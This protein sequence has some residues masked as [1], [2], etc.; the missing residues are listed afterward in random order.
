MSDDKKAI[1]DKLNKLEK[2]IN[3]NHEEA[4]DLFPKHWLILLQVKNDLN[5]KDKNST[6][7]DS[8]IGKVKR[9]DLEKMNKI[10]RINKKIA[11]IGSITEFRK[12][13]YA[14]IDEFI[15]ADEKASAI[16][17]WQDNFVQDDGSEFTLT[18]ANKIIDERK[19]KLDGS[20][21]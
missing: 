8:P 11:K 21:S 2:L 15:Q 18:E 13:V 5:A 20:N 7:K 1:I 6:G 10:W 12:V 19:E 17:V 9:S 16:R 4:E 14:A 3:K